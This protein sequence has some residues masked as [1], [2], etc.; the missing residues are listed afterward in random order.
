[1]QAVAG[2]RRGLTID[3]AGEE[4]A[5]A[6]RFGRLVRESPVVIFA[7]RG[8][9]M[10]HVMKS[11]LAAVGAH[12]TVIELEGPAEERAAVEAGG[13]AAVPALF[14]GGAPVGGLEGLMGLHLSGLLVPRLREVG[15]LRA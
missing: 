15:A 13:H 3:P 12:A 1:M 6:Q 8:C 11:L 2:I 10:A 5:P 4:E 9:Y 7:R 14:V